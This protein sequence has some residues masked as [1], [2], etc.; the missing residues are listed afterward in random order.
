MLI[1]IFLQATPTIKGNILHIACLFLPNHQNPPGAFMSKPLRRLR[2]QAGL[3]RHHLR[4]HSS[5]VEQVNFIYT[6]EYPR[7]HSRCSTSRG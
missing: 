6:T 5:P 2:R 4:Y 7:P 1:G 3:P